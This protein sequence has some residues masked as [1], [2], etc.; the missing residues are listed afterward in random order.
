[1]TDGFVTDRC[2]SGGGEIDVLVLAGGKSRRMGT[3]KATVM[4]DGMPLLARVVRAV[5]HVGDVQVLGGPAATLDVVKAHCADDIRLSHVVD[6]AD[7]PGPFG[8]IVHG[9]ERS[10]ANVALIVSC[11]LP[12]LRPQDVDRLLAARQ[13]GDAELAV[14]LVG[15]RRQWHALAVSQRVV[16][17]LTGRYAEGVRSLRRGFSGLSECAVVSADQNFFRDV[18][19]PEDLRGLAL[20]DVPSILS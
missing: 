8:A 4:V 17:M 6:A 16:P 1:M 20:D 12:T 3:D 18:D 2:N 11:D 15:G 13:S 5:A 7:D 10:S 9:L 19:T 14:P